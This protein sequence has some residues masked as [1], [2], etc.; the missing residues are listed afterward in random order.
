MSYRDELIKVAAVAV[1]MIEDYDTGSTDL[2]DPITLD[3]GTHNVLIEVGQ[4]RHRQ[5]RKWGPQHHSAADWYTILG[6]EF[7]EVGH[8]I[9]EGD[10]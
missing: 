3:N 10:F 7:G 4:E 2:S 6:E 1:A 5:E 8:A 9:N